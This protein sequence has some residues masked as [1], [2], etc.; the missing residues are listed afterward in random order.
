MKSKI[1]LACLFMASAACAQKSGFYTG[2]GAVYSKFH[3]DVK[4]RCQPHD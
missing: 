4:V 1:S 2:V 3:S